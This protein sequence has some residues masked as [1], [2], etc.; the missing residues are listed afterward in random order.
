[1]TIEVPTPSADLISQIETQTIQTDETETAAIAAIRERFAPYAKHNGY[2]R[3]AH[4]EASTCN[5]SVDRSVYY[6]DAGGKRVKALLACDS[7]ST[8][9]ENQ[10]NGSLGGRRL[11][12]LSTGEWLD[13]KRYGSW[14]QW[15]GSPNHWGCGADASPNTDDGDDSSSRGYAKIVTDS[16]VAADWDLA[17]VLADL[18]KAMATMCNK[19]PARFTALQGRAELARRIL[20][21]L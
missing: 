6:K 16:E 5:W 1:M 2:V 13:I 17:E 7:F 18:G 20:E 19:L 14:T 4:Y 12:L 21:N 9:S 10:N 3:I 8:G 11:Y 15:Q